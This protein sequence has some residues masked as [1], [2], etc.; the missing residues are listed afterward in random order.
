MSKPTTTSHFRKPIA[1]LVT[2]ISACSEYVRSPTGI[3]DGFRALR[4]GS[5]F[6]V[7]SRISKKTF[8]PASL[9][10]SRTAYRSMYAI[11]IILADIVDEETMVDTYLTT[12]QSP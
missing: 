11:T 4:M 1:N 7:T 12:R 2:S 6:Q 3:A 9:L 8:A 5:V 10:R